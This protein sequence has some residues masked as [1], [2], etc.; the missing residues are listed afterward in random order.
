MLTDGTSVS[1]PANG[2]INAF[3]GRPSEFIGAA[4]IMRLLTV[5]DAAGVQV[6][7]LV[8]VGGVQSAP[9]AAGTSVNVSA[10]AGAGPKDD[11]DTVA[12]QV[13]LAAG[14]RVQLNFTNTTGAAVVARYR[15]LIVP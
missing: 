11:E 14:S 5:A 13:A 10:V 4:S 1:V 3:L 9:I 2:S 12:P 6:Q 15:A 8:N 7:M